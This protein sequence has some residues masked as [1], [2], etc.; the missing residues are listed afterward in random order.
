MYI[1]IMAAERADL[2]FVH[3]KCSWK[4]EFDYIGYTGEVHT[5]QIQFHTRCNAFPVHF[6]HSYYFL[7]QD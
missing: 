1:P 3:V 5:V 7:Y 6:S 4:H 2:D